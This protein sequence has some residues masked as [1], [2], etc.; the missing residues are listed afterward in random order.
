MPER[1]KLPNAAA[2][3]A[4][5]VDALNNCDLNRIMA[6]YPDSGPSAN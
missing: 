1:K 6:Q 3:V 2:V 4:E 5:H